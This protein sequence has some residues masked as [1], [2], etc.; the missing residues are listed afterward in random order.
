MTNMDANGK[1]IPDGINDFLAKISDGEHFGP[2]DYIDEPIER[3]VL[4]LGWSIQRY[5]KLLA[6]N[7]PDCAIDNEHKL[8]RKYYFAI[9]MRKQDF[10]KY[11]RKLYKNIPDDAFLTSRIPELCASTVHHFRGE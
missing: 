10:I 9:Q 8:S 3:T 7:A 6:L 1:D 4:R 5:A 11:M 2:E